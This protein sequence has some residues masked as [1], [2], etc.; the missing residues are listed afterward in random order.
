MSSSLLPERTGDAETPNGNG[1]CYGDGDDMTPRESRRRGEL[2]FTALMLVTM[3]VANGIDVTDDS[4]G[5]Y[6]TPLSS[7]TLACN[8][9]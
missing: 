7:V 8:R 2:C 5:Y 6:Y 9:Q 4:E 3:A 1:C